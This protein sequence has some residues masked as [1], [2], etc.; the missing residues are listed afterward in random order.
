VTVDDEARDLRAGLSF[1]VGNPLPSRLIDAARGVDLHTDHWVFPDT[2]GPR[3]PDDRAL[4]QLRDRGRSLREIA[5]E[6]KV[7]M[8]VPGDPGWP[9][10][11][12]CDD[13]PCLWV[14]GNTDLA[15]LLGNAVA[16]TGSRAGSDYGKR[17]AG[18]L[19]AELIHRGWT[20][21][22]TAS[23]GIDREILA[24]VLTLTD[25]APLLI[26]ANGLDMGFGSSLAG[27]VD[28]AIVRGAVVS[29]FPPGRA[30]SL[31]RTRVRERLL[32]NLTAA[33]V[34]VEASRRS[35]RVYAARHAADL[36]RRICAVPGRI[37][38]PGSAGCLQLLVEGTALLVTTASDVIEAIG[39]TGSDSGGRVMFTVHAQARQGDGTQHHVWQVPAFHVRAVSP[40]HAANTALDIIASAHHG[41]LD[42]AVTVQGPTGDPETI[43]ISRCG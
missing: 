15:G 3:I 21:V 34:L 38:S 43:T 24:T 9:V 10:G 36:G 40:A 17:V 19:T 16:V 37:T 8:L 18:D 28:E 29:P 27:L 20:I 2:E 42:L 33:S 12:S 23:Q 11:T 25:T 1:Y 4:A 35:P 13:L 22:T 32:F 31:A 5:V 26:T 7:S 41:P 14:R 30:H 6:A 39:D